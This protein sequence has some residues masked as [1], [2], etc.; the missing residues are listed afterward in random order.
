MHAEAVNKLK[1][2]PNQCTSWGELS[3]NLKSMTSTEITA[4]Q[5]AEMNTEKAFE[6]AI[7]SFNKLVG[8]IVQ[9]GTRFSK[10]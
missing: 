2:L 10:S 5:L 6:D 4:E 8:T 1:A 7:T 9:I 3:E